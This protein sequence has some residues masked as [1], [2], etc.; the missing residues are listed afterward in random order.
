MKK[1]QLTVPALLEERGRVRDQPQLRKCCENEERPVY[2][3]DPA[4]FVEHFH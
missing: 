3:L 1:F 2:Y 4:H